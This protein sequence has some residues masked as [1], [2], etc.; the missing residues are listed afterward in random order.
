M[1]LVTWNLNGL[2]EAHLDDRTEAAVFT[3]ILGARLDQLHAGTTPTAPPDVIV[4][5]EVTARMFSASIAR[6]LPAGGYSV[7]PVEAPDR[8][9]FE[10]IAFRS[11]MQLTD[12]NIVPLA[13]SNY[14]R[15]LHTLDVSVEAGVPLR[16]LTAHFDSGTD[17]AKVRTAQLKQVAAVITDHGVF[18][19]DA[20]LRKAE[21]DTIKDHVHMSDAWEALGRPADTRVTWV[22]DEYKARFDRVFFGA[23]VAPISMSGLGKDPLPGTGAAISDHF[24]LS[25][26]FTFCTDER[27]L[28]PK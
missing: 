22:R 7:I 20:N 25:F 1:R 5:Q 8:E 11:S 12:Y 3:M 16:I 15:V 18:A 23:A 9:V 27:A 14:S 26:D 6:H 4:L 10:V 24:G 2:E 13:A 19:G 28:S 17:A 21:W